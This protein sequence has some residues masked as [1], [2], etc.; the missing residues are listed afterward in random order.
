MRWSTVLFIGGVIALCVSMSRVPVVNAHHYDDGSHGGYLFPA[1]QAYEMNG[2]TVQGQSTQ[3]Q[4]QTFDS[5]WAGALSTSITNWNSGM[6][7]TTGFNVYSSGSANINVYAD[8]SQVCDVGA[9]GCVKAWSPAVPSAEIH[10]ETAYFTFQDHRVSDL[11]HEMGHVIFHAGEH[12][13]TYDCTSI[14]G[15]SAKEFSGAAGY[16]GTGLGSDVLTVVQSHDVSDYVSAYGVRET[17]DAIYVNMLGSATLVHYFEGGWYGGIG[18]T[19]HQEYENVIDR[20]TSN[21]TGGYSFYHSIGRKVSN[22]DDSTPENQSYGEEPGV[23]A[24]WCFKMHGHTHALASGAANEWGP[25]SH[26]YCIAH[27]GAGSGVFVTSDRNNGNAN[28]RV[29]NFSGAAIPNVQI[30]TQ[31]SPGTQIC[32]FGT[33]NNNAVSATCSSGVGGPG[34]LDLWYNNSWVP[35]D[36]I[37]YDGN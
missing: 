8:T 26:R 35:L 27:S 4:L 31:P 9:H 12:Y 10:M 17:Q 11:M 32:N 25:Y 2:T 23:N 33:I 6:S 18:L 14:M 37:G 15:H 13:P 19:V 24:E 30:R 16:C 20:S 21:I 1:A 36:T 22:A 5:D 29:W 28:F 3:I 34:I 7:S